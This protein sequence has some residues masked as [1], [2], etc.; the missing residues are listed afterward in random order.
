MAPL[1]AP[2]RPETLPPSVRGCTVRTS[3]DTGGEAGVTEYPQTPILAKIA[4][5]VYAVTQLYM[6]AL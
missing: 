6:R 1:I 2:V 5:A 4:I 3:T